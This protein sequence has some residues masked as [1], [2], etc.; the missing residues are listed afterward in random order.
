MLQY[1]PNIK[2]LGFV[3][4]DK[5]IFKKCILKTFFYTVTNLCNQSEPFK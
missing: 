3:V 2:A 1:I 5:K 4:L